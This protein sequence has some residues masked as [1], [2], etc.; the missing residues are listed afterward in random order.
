MLP[1]PAGPP[2]AVNST[3]TNT[4]PPPNTTQ[5][6]I[7]TSPSYAP[8]PT[9]HSY[10]APT[11]G[12]TPDNAAPM[13]SLYLVQTPHNPNP[14]HIYHLRSRLTTPT[15]TRRNHSR[16][17]WAILTGIAAPTATHNSF[18]DLPINPRVPSTSPNIHSGHCSASCASPPALHQSPPTTHLWSNLLSRPNTNRIGTPT[19]THPNL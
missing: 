5:P 10:P 11:R 13:T 17:L 2:Q 19:S 15:C 9:R 3:T 1:T 14:Q 16:L 12:A 18:S 6:N 7:T 4:S 8:T